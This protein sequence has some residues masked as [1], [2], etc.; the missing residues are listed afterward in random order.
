MAEISKHTFSSFSYHPSCSPFT[1]SSEKYKAS[2]PGAKFKYLATGALVF[3]NFNPADPRILLIQRAAGDSM[4]GLWEV[5]GG[6]VD[7][8]DESI[9]HAVARELWEE[10]AL[11]AATIGPRVGEPHYFESRSG[12]RVARYSFMVE[13]KSGQ[14]AKDVKLD[15]KEH[16]NF[17]W[18]TQEQVKARK[19]GDLI[20]ELT[21]N[22]AEA[23]ILEAFKIRRQGEIMSKSS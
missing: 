11:T 19:I 4:S 10:A 21:S 20:L 13:M 12:K 17:V 3:D 23:T 22:E 2:N 5:P 14:T 8:E 6:G 16:Q 18:A 15:P 1:V 7:D 9:L